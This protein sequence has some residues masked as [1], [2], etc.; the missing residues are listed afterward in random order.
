MRARLL[1]SAQWYSWAGNGYAAPQHHDWHGI[2]N[3]PRFRVIFAE[4][5]PIQKTVNSYKNHEFIPPHG[6]TS[7]NS[8]VKKYE[9]ISSVTYNFVHMNSYVSYWYI[10]KMATD[11]GGGGAGGVTRRPVVGVQI[12]KKIFIF[13]VLANFAILAISTYIKPNIWFQNG[14]I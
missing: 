10:K 5:G 7:M 13:F 3:F 12:P 11:G 14:Y 8:Y 1:T 2:I 6:E 9:F 4:I